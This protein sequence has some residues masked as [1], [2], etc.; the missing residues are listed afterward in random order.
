[1]K[2]ILT[3]QSYGIPKID[4]NATTGILLLEGRSIPEH[5]KAL[6]LPLIEWVNNYI[7]SPHSLTEFHLK[8]DYLNSSSFKFLI[9]LLKQ[10]NPIK[11]NAIVKWYYEVDDDEM[12]DIGKELQEI[13]KI[14]VEIIGVEEFE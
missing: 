4:F 6:Y 12:S 5:P 10:L 1:M 7:K 2:N 11:D 8:V 9:T 14:T 13:L 3:P